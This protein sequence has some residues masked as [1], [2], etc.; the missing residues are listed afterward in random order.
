MHLLMSPHKV[1]PDASTT[2]VVSNAQLSAHTITYHV[3]DR[4]RSLVPGLGHRVFLFTFVTYDAST[5]VAIMLRFGDNPRDRERDAI[6][7]DPEFTIFLAT[8]CAAA[9]G[10]RVV[11]EPPPPPPP[12]QACSSL[13]W[14]AS[15]LA[16]LYW[17][18][19]R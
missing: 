1:A 11:D 2:T 4:V 10:L 18:R 9:G 13:E 6:V 19:P 12:P 8:P 7:A 5:L 3:S 15:A 16:S 17:A 14:R